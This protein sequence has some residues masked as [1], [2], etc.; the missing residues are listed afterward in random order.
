MYTDV[1]SSGVVTMSMPCVVNA[2]GK[3]SRLKG[4]GRKGS[5]VNDHNRAMSKRC[6]IAIPA[7]CQT[8][9]V[10]AQRLIGSEKGKSTIMLQRGMS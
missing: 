7:G 2:W 1:S 4:A 6:W 10:P 9:V 8:F 3:F 5:G